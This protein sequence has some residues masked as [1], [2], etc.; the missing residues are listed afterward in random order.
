[1]TREQVD[2]RLRDYKRCVGRCAHLELEVDELKKQRGTV[3]E[4]IIDEAAYA[5]ASTP[6]EAPRDQTISKPTEQGAVRIENDLRAEYAR[7]DERITEL[8]DELGQ[9]QLTILFVDAWVS[10]LNEREKWVI[11]RCVLDGEYLRSAA[12]EWNMIHSSALTKRHMQR[13]K[14]EALLKIYEMAQ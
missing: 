13:I 11:T 2:A 8:E 3:Y 9:L 14:N 1:M 10:G 6:S 12:A 5:S 7:I 4:R